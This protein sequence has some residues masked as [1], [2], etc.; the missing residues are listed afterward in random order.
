MFV[1]YMSSIFLIIANGYIDARKTSYDRKMD[2]FNELKL[3]VL[4]YHMMLFTQFVPDA[5][6]R[7]QIGFSC[8]GFLVLSTAINMFLLFVT[9][10]RLL[11]RLC[12]IR[13]HKKKA[14]KA[15]KLLKK[16][17]IAKGTRQRGKA[18]A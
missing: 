18:K 7:Y 2:R 9:P 10:F 5:G 14:K 15:A 3:I 13:Y 12:R 17:K 16:L 8:A 4:M 1:L 6:V 11:Q